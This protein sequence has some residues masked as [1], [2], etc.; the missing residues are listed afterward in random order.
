MVYAK[1]G[2]KTLFKLIGI[3]SVFFCGM[4][5]S[6]YTSYNVTEISRT[7]TKG[8]RLFLTG[9]A[10]SISPL[11]YLVNLT[12]RAPDEKLKSQVIIWWADLVRGSV[13]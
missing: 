4:L 12:K 9:R 2:G 8:G 3:L 1:D 7:T 13:S 11:S 6:H 10:M 5:M